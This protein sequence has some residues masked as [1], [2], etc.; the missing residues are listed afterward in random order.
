MK[1]K[2]L[3]ENILRSVKSKGFK[4]IELPSVIEASHI[5]Q[6]SG[7]SFRKFIFL[8][9]DQTGNELCLRPDLTIVSCLRYL[10]NNLKG[11]E[12]IFYSGQAYR[13][14]QNKKDSI[15]RNQVGFEII[16][17]RDEKNDDKEIIDTSLKSL[18]N[19]KYSTGTLTIGNVEIFNLLISKLDIPKRWK[20]RLTRHFWRED[21]FSDLLKRLE[22]N[23]DVDPTIVEV[24]KRRYLK[25]LKG[26]QSKVVA[27]RSIKEILKRFDHKIKDPR[28]TNKGKNVSKI[29]KDFLR[30]K[31][32]INKAASELN[33]FFKKYK[34]N[35]AVDQ[36]Y[37]PLSQNKVSKLNVIFSAS[38]GRQLEYYT[39]MVFRI[40]IKS[41]LKNKNVINGGRY[42]HLISDLGSKKE[43]PA[44]GAA[45]NI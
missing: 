19:L 42:D 30:I 22:T 11:K 13:K 5:V 45:I 29:I 6:R 36:R 38:F 39:G 17:S 25:M 44:V 21:Y 10:E 27:G 1:S 35:L 37:F 26:N 33:K 28:R 20:L 14:S 41:N 31:C 24:D 18:K 9:T 7:E 40:D 2:N 32:P 43:V 34:I 12:K 8:F 23:S 4:Y 15:I 3:S 16:G